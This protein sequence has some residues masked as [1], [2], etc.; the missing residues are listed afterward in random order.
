MSERI[1]T[2]DDLKEILRSEIEEFRE[3]G[4]SFVNGDMTMMQFK[5]LSGGFGV[6]AH[7]AGTEFMIRLRIP[8][9]VTDVYELKKV[10]GFAE[11]YNVPRIHF[12][13]R[14]AAQLHGLSI[15]EVCDLMEEALDADIYTRGAGGNYPRNVALSP[16]AGVNPEEP[17]DSTPYALAVGNYF[18]ERIYTY[19]LPRKLKVSFSNSNADGAHCTFQDLGFLAVDDNGKKAFRIYIGGGIG[20]NPKKA[21]IYPELIDVK[22]VLYYVE[23]MVKFYMA[24]GNYENRARARVRYILDRMGEEEFLKTYKKYAEEE[25]RGTGL[26]VELE[27]RTYTKQGDGST[28]SSPRVYEQK[29]E[30]LYSVY[31]HPVGGQMPVNTLREL[32]NLLDKF[33]D[34]DIRLAMTE[35]IYVRNLTGNEAEMVL[36]ATESITDDKQIYHSTSCVGAPICQIGMGNSQELLASIVSYFKKQNYY[37]DILPKVYISGCGNSCSVHQIGAIGFTGRRKKV[38]DEMKEC[39]TL[40]LGGSFSIDNSKMGKS[41]GEIMKDDIP[42]FLYQLSKTIEESNITFDDFIENH[43]EELENL[44]NKYIV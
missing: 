32:V 20:Q 22:K 41:Y 30:G 23:A 25:L 36:K 19:K 15:D 35:G 17:F 29:Q 31:I 34:I 7:R 39:F 21:V 27:P 13:T 26:D 40:F 28:V 8:S 43:E 10:V 3:K 14:Q 6:Y 4:H 38:N 24:E 18:L 16:L 42:E 33:K 37:K 9:G 2:M 11:K 44:I 1:G 12:T 5:H